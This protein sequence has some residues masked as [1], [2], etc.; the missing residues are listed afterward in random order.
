MSV[1]G[2]G[3]SNVRGRS[4]ARDV[5]FN[6]SRHQPVLDVLCDHFSVHRW[7]FLLS[8]SRSCCAEASPFLSSLNWSFFSLW[9]RVTP[10]T[11]ANGFAHCMG[12]DVIAR[13]CY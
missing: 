2:R 1:A 6:S 7:S 5:F 13:D 4:Y 11:V 3:G 12:K 10:V 8:Q 9:C